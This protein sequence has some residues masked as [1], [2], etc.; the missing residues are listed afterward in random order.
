[1]VKKYR[2]ARKRK[3]RSS[4]PTHVG[5]QIF[6]LLRSMGG[7]PQKARLAKLWNEWLEVMGNEFSGAIPLGHKDG[8][9]FLGV[10]DSM[11]MQELGLQSSLILEKV[12][13]YM[14]EEYFSRLR[15]T[16]HITRE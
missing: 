15:V 10:E 7:S 9:L 3:R 2:K 6:A 16:L 4:I 13:D 12:N 14:E 1:M 11:E 5:G 8:T